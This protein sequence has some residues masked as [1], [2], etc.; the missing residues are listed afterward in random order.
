MSPESNRSLHCVC[1]IPARYGSTR[2]PGKPLRLIGDKPMIQWVYEQAGKAEGIDQVLVATDHEAILEAVQAFGGRAVMT[3][4]DLPSGTDRVAEVVK[5]MNVDVVIN[6][7][8]DEPFISPELLNRMVDIFR[9]PDVQIA[10]PVHRITTYEDLIDPNL[11]RVVRNRERFALYFTRSVIPYCRDEGRKE[12]WIGHTAYYKHVG[13]YA[14]RKETLLELTKLPE[15]DLEKAERLEQLRMLENGY[16]IYTIETDYDA[17][18]V[19]TKEDL[20]RVN[21]LLKTKRLRLDE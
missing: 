8:G 19:D 15:S 18:C 2:L 3:S 17:I 4:T 20:E 13:L 12:N 10:T 7:Q 11:V 1:V 6:L 14:Y 16:S 9:R 5:S 21:S